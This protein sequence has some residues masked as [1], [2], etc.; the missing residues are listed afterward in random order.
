MAGAL[1]DVAAAEAGQG[2]R[3]IVELRLGGGKAQHAVAAAGD[4]QRRLADR[5][6]TPGTAELPVAPEVAVPVQAAAEAGAREFLRV[7]VEVG[8]AQPRRQLGRID[9]VAEQ[10][11][12]GPSAKA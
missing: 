11:S 6:A 10:G 4:E 8:L 9:G 5:L 7:V 2:V 12:R 1:E 3:E